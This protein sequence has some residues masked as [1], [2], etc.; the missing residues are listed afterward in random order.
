[1][2][3]STL[4]F[5]STE[6][7]RNTLMARNL[8][9]YN[10][11][12]VYSPQ[13]SNLTYETIQSNYSVINSPDNLIAEDPFVNQFYPLNEFGPDGGFNTT[14]TFNGPLLHR[15]QCRSPLLY[16]NQSSRWLHV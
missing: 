8:A 15:I 5:A 13:V 7:F 4:S 12:G 14:I 10:V 9:P 2:S 1:M 16:T 3:E 11:V 6:T